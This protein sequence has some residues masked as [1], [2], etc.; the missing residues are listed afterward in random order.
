[1]FVGSDIKLTK[2]LTVNLEGRFVD[3]KAFT[4]GLNYK[5]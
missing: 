5:F 3:E 2:N 4:I 1:V